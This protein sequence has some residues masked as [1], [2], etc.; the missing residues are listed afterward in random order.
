MFKP[1]DLFFARDLQ[2]PMQQPIIEHT[3]SRRPRCDVNVERL[4]TITFHNQRDFVFFRHYRQNW[5]GVEE[6][7]RRHIKKTWSLQVTGL[8]STGFVVCI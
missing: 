4:R 1:T 3:R 7:V 2:Q 8:V 6:G 5:P